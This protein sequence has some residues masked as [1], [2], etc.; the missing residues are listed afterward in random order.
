MTVSQRQNL[1]KISLIQ[2]SHYHQPHTK[3]TPTLTTP[4][5]IN[6]FYSVFYNGQIPKSLLNFEP[7][8]LHEAYSL[9]MPDQ[10]L[11]DAYGKFL[12]DTEKSV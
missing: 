10:P 8:T 1:L 9:Y 5:Q 7:L 3:P 12:A 4:Q 2:K 11:E 6:Q